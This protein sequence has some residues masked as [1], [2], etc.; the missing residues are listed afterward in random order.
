[1]TG[2]LRPKTRFLYL[3]TSFGKVVGL[4]KLTVGPPDGEMSGVMLREECARSGSIM[5][6]KWVFKAFKGPGIA[7]L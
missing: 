1:M 5:G 3:L 4:G 2:V 7:A 6:V